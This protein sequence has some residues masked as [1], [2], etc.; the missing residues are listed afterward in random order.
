MQI[1]QR[2]LIAE[3]NDGLRQK[4]YGALCD[5]GVSVDVSADGVDAIDK[6]NRVRY[7]VA[8]IDLA[9]PIVD[10]EALVERVRLLPSS[11]RPMMIITAQRGTKLTLDHEVVQV[12][13]RKPYDLRQVSDLIVSCLRTM[14]EIGARRALL[15]SDRPEARP[16]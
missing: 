2:V 16:C 5:A 1:A 15:R 10:G 9:L 11:E 13:M 6:L 14:A 3:A 7:G 12:V 4:L 8:I